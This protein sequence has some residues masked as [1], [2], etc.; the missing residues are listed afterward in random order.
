M[1]TEVKKTALFLLKMIAIVAIL[2]FALGTVL[3]KLYNNMTVGEKARAHY[4][5]SKDTSDV[6]IFG[7]SRALYHYN[8]GMLQDSL[9]TTV[10]NA[11]RSN[12]TILYHLA[13]FKHIL[14]R[15]T[16]KLVV[17]DVN[18][19][20]L[21]K[22]PKKYDLLSALLPYGRSDRDMLLQ[23][24]QVNPGYKIWSWSRTLPYNSSLVAILYR[25]LTKGKDKD[26]HGYLKHDGILKEELTTVDNCHVPYTIDPLLEEAYREMLSLCKAHRIDIVV[27]VSPRY[28]AYACERKE[29]KALQQLSLKEGVTIHDFSQSLNNAAWFADPSHLNTAGASRYTTMLIPLLRGHLH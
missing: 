23:Y 26:I 18:E 22:N 4:V 9:N 16:P 27:T 2:D 5:I 20:E 6:L 21:V 24:E 25:G 17:L 8:A 10:Y 12:Q 3:E 11:G 28:S 1:N 13:I 19:D 7:S 15:H 14:T 29:Y